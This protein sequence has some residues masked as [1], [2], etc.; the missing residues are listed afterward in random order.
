MTNNQFLHLA[1]LCI[2]DGGVEFNRFEDLDLGQC[3][4]A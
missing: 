1:G 2:S 3:F 4:F